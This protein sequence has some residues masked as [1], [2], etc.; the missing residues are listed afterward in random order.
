MITERFARKSRSRRQQF[1]FRGYLSSGELPSRKPESP[2]R[3]PKS[4][5]G[6]A[7]TLR[8][9]CPR[10]GDCRPRGGNCGREEGTALDGRVTAVCG[11][12]L[13]RETA[14]ENRTPPVRGPGVF[15]NA[16][17]H[18]KKWRW[19]ELNPRPMRLCQ[20]FSGRSMRRDFSAPAIM[21]TSG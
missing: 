17:R 11:R 9:T 4:P 5:S 2:S 1:T 3:G 13:P 20:G 14:A 21:H 19:G 10:E 12:E 7:V 18:V 6:A 15:P 16:I 8:L